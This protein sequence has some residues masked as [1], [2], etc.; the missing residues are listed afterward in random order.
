VWKH[1]KPP[2][3]CSHKYNLSVIKFFGNVWTSH[4]RLFIYILSI[5]DSFRLDLINHFEISNKHWGI[6]MYG[7][8]LWLNNTYHKVWKFTTVSK[9][10]RFYRWELNYYINFLFLGNV[11][12]ITN[13]KPYGH[14]KIVNYIL[15]V[16][17]FYSILPI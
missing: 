3:N 17:W 7:L 13:M 15:Y 4:L 14:W 8:Y 9:K 1:T 5:F 2:K 10:R 11:S 6:W 12:W 16:H